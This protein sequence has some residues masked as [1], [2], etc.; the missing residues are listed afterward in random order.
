MTCC[1]CKAPNVKTTKNGLCTA[2]KARAAGNGSMRQLRRMAAQHWTE[3][4]NA[5][6]LIRYRMTHREAIERAVLLRR[7]LL[8]EFD[9]RTIR[10]YGLDN[11]YMQEHA[12]KTLIASAR[13]MQEA[14]D[15]GAGARKPAQPE[16]RIILATGRKAA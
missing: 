14:H 5:V 7:Q 13:T 8:R 11:P 9:S 10:I 2:C 12:R 4:N 15:I 6:L 3:G 1:G 16:R